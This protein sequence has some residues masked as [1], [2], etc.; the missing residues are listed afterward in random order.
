MFN[1]AFKKITIRSALVCERIGGVKL[2]LYSGSAEGRNFQPLTR[3]QKKI[4]PGVTEVDEGKFEIARC[5][6]ERDGV[7]NV[8]GLIEVTESPAGSTV[9]NRVEGATLS[10]KIIASSILRPLM[11]IDMSWISTSARCLGS[12]RSK[13]NAYQALLQRPIS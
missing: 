1:A 8:E 9:P 12:W 3:S 7:V 5:A 6:A 11:P 4:S 10:S 2:K 13:R